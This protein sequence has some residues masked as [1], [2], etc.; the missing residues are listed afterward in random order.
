MSLSLVLTELSFH[1]PLP[2]NHMV[3]LHELTSRNDPH[4]AVAWKILESNFPR[5]ELEERDVV[6]GEIGT[7]HGHR[8]WLVHSL[9]GKIAGVVRGKLLSKLGCGWIVH[10]ALTPDYRGMNLGTSMV[11]AAIDI[12]R[13]LAENQNSVYAGTLFEVE[14]IDDTIPLAVIPIRKKRLEFFE[15]LGTTILT[16][17]YW[18]PPTRPDTDWIRMNLI[19]KAEPRL[20]LSRETLIR[21]FYQEAFAVAENHPKVIQALA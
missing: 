9:E 11:Q 8:I 14:I 15:K 18:Q 20:T 3:K 10:M 16:D 21:G 13:R 5:E 7:S 1:R 12:L 6:L 19:L 2:T 4:A 17:H